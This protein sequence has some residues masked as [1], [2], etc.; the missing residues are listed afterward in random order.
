MMGVNGW[1]IAKPCSHV[2]MV[3][4]G[5]NPLDRYGTN[6]KNMLKLA[7]AS[8]LRTRPARQLS[9]VNARTMRAR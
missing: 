3:S 8:T 5:T 6:R 2:G 9:H 4:T 1:C 7:A